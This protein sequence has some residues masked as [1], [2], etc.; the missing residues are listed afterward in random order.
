[1]PSEH[2]G[3]GHGTKL[4]T[5]AVPGMHECRARRGRATA[6]THQSGA[7]PKESPVTPSYTTPAATED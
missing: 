3:L 7:R 5:H 4:G 1:M 2:R 6:N